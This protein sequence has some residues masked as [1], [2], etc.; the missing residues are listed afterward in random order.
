MPPLV[1]VAVK[2]N[3]VPAQAGFVPEVNAIATEGVT[4][5]S[6][7]IVIPFE[8]AVVGTAH[9]LFDVITHVTI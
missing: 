5:G 9:G 8:V 7:V 3:D 2:V 6:M 4:D 1:G